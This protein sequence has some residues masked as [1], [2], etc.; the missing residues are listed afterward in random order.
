MSWKLLGALAL[1]AMAVTA[2]G[3]DAERMTAGPAAGPGNGAG[4][5]VATGNAELTIRL[6]G[7]EFDQLIYRITCGPAGATVQPPV[8]GVEA[9]AACRR[10]A[11]PATS[12]LL[13]DGPDPDR[14]CTEVYGGPQE[15]RLTGSVA[16]RAV[17]ATVRR[18]NGC[19][20]DSWDR[21]LADVL[22]PTQGA[23]AGG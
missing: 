8:A 13:V 9:E 20:I 18:T 17:D 10:L 12:S 7:G 16:G 4:D 22:P 15:A 5:P 11:D 1:L 2:C 23:Q 19:E 3:D 21:L 14:I 6:S